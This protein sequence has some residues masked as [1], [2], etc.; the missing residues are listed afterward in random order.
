M[1]WQE[2]FVKLGLMATDTLGRKSEPIELA[3]SADL[4]ARIAVHRSVSAYQRESILMRIDVMDG[5]LPAVGSVTKFA[6]GPVLSTME[7][8]VTILA[9][10]R[11]IR[12]VKIGVAIAAGNSGMA[13]S[14]R[15]AGLSVIEFDLPGN[16]LPI[17][18]SVTCLAGKVEPSV[19][20]DGRGQRT[21][22]PRT[23]ANRQWRKCCRDED[24]SKKRHNKSPSLSGRAVIP[25]DFPN[26]YGRSGARTRTGSPLDNKRSRD[27]SKQSIAS[28]LK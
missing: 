2:G 1:I 24:E 4:V 13:T 14:Q 9:L 19:R 8:G 10:I 15:K 20:A 25:V 27:L 12:E 3:N 23:C 5:N 11:S 17:L 16:H 6:F 22:R 26:S 18:R 28:D 21:G 7:V